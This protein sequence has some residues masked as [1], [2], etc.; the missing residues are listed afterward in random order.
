METV[1][2]YEAKTHLPKLLER[3]IK[4]E[5]ITITK[6]GIPVAVL[7]PPESLRKAEPKRVIA[8]VRSFR[9]KHRLNGLSLREM[10]KEGRP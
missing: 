1:G 9:A 4:G 7:Q 5:R 3:V 6:H 10:I 8:E 2:A